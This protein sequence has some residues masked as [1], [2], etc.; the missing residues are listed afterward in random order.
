[1]GTPTPYRIPLGKK[2]TGAAIMPRKAKAW[3]GTSCLF[4]AFYRVMSQAR[5]PT[6]AVI[7]KP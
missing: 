1:M 4:L 5:H 3:R 6:R 2:I 7:A